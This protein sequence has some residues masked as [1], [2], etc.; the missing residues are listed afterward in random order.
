MT[1]PSSFYDA[2]SSCYH[3]I[4]PDWEAS[5]TRQGRAL[6]SIIRSEGGS[7]FWTV[8]DAACGIG[9]QSLALAALHYEVTASDISPAAVE[10]ARQ[11]AGRRGLSIQGS[12]CDMRGVHE[13][14]ARMFD[15]VLA[16]DNSVPHLLSDAEILTSFRQ[17][18]ACTKPGGICLISVRDYAGVDLTE[19][20]QF[21]PYGV[22]EV[23]GV[24]YVLF[25]IWELNP[26][27]YDT[28][29]YLVE[30]REGSE[31]VAHSSLTT[32]YAVA[33]R[34][35]TEIME[36]AGFSEVHRIDDVFFQPVIVGHKSG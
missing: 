23:G 8:L 15:V 18:H 30:H 27:L 6:D 26:P 31:P 22:R 25:Q 20:L 36:Q 12:V 1:S 16:C 9:T 21:H 3:L 11:E 33:I 2:L 4:Y 13:H 10:R 7:Q 34:T 24:R 19:K 35:L 5:M 17:F 29:F 14:H 32:Y 28:T